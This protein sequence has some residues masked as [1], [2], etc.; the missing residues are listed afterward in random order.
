M[1]LVIQQPYRRLRS[2]TTVGHDCKC[3][4]TGQGRSPT[5]LHAP[6]VLGFSHHPGSG[7]TTEAP[8]DSL[9]GS[10]VRIGTMQRRLA[11]PLR[12]DDAHKSRSEEKNGSPHVLILVGA[13]RKPRRPLVMYHMIRSKQRDP[14]LEDNSL[15]RKDTSTYMRFHSTFA[16]LFYY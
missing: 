11:W 15:I 1:F 8:L 3:E 12:K 2:M 16:A 7:K 6:A 5:K 4:E 9:R 14:N 10:S 13:P